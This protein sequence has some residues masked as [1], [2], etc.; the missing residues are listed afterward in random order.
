MKNLL[1]I[2]ALGLVAMSGCKRTEVVQTTA[3]RDS[4]IYRDSIKL[5]EVEVPGEKVMVEIPV[6]ADCDSCMTLLQ[7]QHQSDRASVVITSRPSTDTSK[8]SLVVEANC[9]EFKTQIQ[10]RDRII[11]NLKDKATVKEVI[12]KVKYVPWY[13]KMSLWV[14]VGLLAYLVIKHALKR[15]QI[16]F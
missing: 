9:E 8:G 12:R 10:A 6:P 3:V 15:I 7:L 4:L 1:Y 13:Y 11:R 2:L 16:P 5:V 14:A